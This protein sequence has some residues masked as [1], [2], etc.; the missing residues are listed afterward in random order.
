MVVCW[1]SIDFMWYSY[2]AICGSLD[3]LWLPMAFLWFSLLV[4]WFQL[5]FNWFPLTSL[6]VHWFLLII[7]DVLWIFMTPMH[8]QTRLHVVV[9]CA[10]ACL[11]ARC[12]LANATSL[13]L[14]CMKEYAC[15]IRACTERTLNS[16]KIWHYFYNEMWF[17]VRGLVLCRNIVKKVW[18][19]L[20]FYVFFLTSVIRDKFKGCGDLEV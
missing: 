10:R 19:C 12:N 8:V 6:G 13:L 11:H 18:Q 2:D 3:F 20:C 4:T 9:N 7:I 15:N 14:F 5:I 1:F 16:I 17:R